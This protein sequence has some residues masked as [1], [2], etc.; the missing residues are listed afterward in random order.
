[1]NFWSGLIVGVIIGAVVML[2]LC[3]TAI[4]IFKEE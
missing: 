1:M 3:R 2:F 4:D